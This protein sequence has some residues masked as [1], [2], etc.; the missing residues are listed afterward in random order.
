MK[1]TFVSTILAFICTFGIAIASSSE[2]TKAAFDIDRELHRGPRD[3]DSFLERYAQRDTD[4]E[5]AF[6]AVLG[7]DDL[8]DNVVANTMLKKMQRKADVAACLNEIC[9]TTGNTGSLTPGVCLPNDD[10]GDRRG[11]RRRG[12]FG[13]GLRG[14]PEELCENVE[15]AEEVLSALTD[16]FGDPFDGETVTNKPARRAIMMLTVGMMM[17]GDF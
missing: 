15:D 7:L 1:A 3:C 9:S 2:P 16:E 14:G 8:S 4:A 6:A 5:E 17:C 13:G 10:E 12:G 11:L